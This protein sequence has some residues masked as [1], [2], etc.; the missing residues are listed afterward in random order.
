MKNNLSQAFRT[1]FRA[2]GRAVPHVAPG[3][4]GPHSP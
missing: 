4:H 1:S 2:L 3:P